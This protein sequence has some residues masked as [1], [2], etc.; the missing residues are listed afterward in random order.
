MT[1]MAGRHIPEPAAGIGVC[2]F[3]A[4][5][6]GAVDGGGFLLMS[7]PDAPAA[8][9]PDLERL[10]EDCLCHIGA[11]L[12]IL[13]RSGQGDLGFMLNCYQLLETA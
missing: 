5:G 2:R 4:V 13:H 9:P 10:W 1:E 3:A 6:A 8:G 7:R 11:L 12:C